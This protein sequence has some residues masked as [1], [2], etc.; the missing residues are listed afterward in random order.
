MRDVSVP[1]IS[2]W[3]FYFADAMLLALAGFILWQAQ[4]PLTQWEV[5][6]MAGCVALGAAFAVW[7][8]IL[9]Y[10]AS[11][12]L[13]E[14]EAL[15]S[16]VAQI[17]N[18]EIVAKRIGDATSQWQSVNEYANKTGAVAKEIADRME[19]EAKEFAEFMQKAND[20][21]KATLR[22]EVEKLRRAEGDWLQVLVRMFDHIFALHAGAVQSGNPQVA[23]QMTHFVNAC[24]DMTRRI[25]LVSFGPQPEEKF[26]PQR[27]Q[28]QNG[29]TP[30][31]D[32]VIERTLAAGYSFQG[33]LLRPAL[34]QV[35]ENVAGRTFENAPSAP[36]SDQSML[37][38]QRSGEA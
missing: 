11:A 21:E 34:V 25:G 23:E 14:S 32:A 6:A 16:V 37:S 10:R 35:K 7:P 31:D 28:V 5:L 2:K 12:K 30:P 1:Q 13:A 26:D 9:D 22:L 3:P 20:S 29:K 33:K 18:L 36:D 4:R 27:H 17:Q 38:F 15:T 8:F 19:T 24:R